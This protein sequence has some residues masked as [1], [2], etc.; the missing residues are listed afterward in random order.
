MVTV[1]RSRCLLRNL[2]MLQLSIQRVQRCNKYNTVFQYFLQP[3]ILST[4]P[5]T[6]VAKSCPRKTSSWE[7]P[8]SLNIPAKSTDIKRSNQQTIAINHRNGTIISL[9]PT[10]SKC[11]TFF[12]PPPAAR[13][14]RVS[15]ST[16]SPGRYVNVYIPRRVEK[17]ASRLSMRARVAR[18]SG[19]RFPF[20]KN[21]TAKPTR[22]TRQR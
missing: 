1:S 2:S 12:S 6:R 3:C 5:G 19:T 7:Q 8:A 11:S 20:Q 22:S 15:P 9:R 16:F 14:R 18:Y 10:L 21:S 4:H 17:S 13:C